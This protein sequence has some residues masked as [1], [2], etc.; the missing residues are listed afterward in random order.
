M[1]MLSTMFATFVAFVAGVMVVTEAVNKLFKVEGQTPKLIVSWVM[2]LGLAAL[3]FGLQLGFFAEIGDVNTWQ[4]WVKTAFIG[5]GCG[6]CANYMYDR[7]EMWHLLEQ[8]FSLFFKK[9]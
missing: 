1:E 3:G 2:S 5:W 6:W 8:I 4:G 9:K 7:D